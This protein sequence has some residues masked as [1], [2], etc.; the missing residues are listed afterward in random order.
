MPNK[1]YSFPAENTNGSVAITGNKIRCEGNS[2]FYNSEV[3][4]DHIQYVYV[5]VNANKESFLFIFDHHQHTIP[6]TSIGFEAVYTELSNRFLFDDALFFETIYK[7][8]PAKKQIWRRTYV[9]TYEI[10]H[11]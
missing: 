10:L 9:P 4:I 7:Q 5:I 8:E 11:T 6:T 3:T 1:K 2:Y